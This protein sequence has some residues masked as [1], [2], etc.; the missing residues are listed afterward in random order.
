MRS[1]EVGRPEV[2]ATQVRV[3]EVG[4]GEDCVREHRVRQLRGAQD[5]A[6]EVVEVLVKR[7]CRAVG[8]PL[9]RLGLA[10]GA[11][12][13]GVIHDD[14]VTV[15]RGDDVIRAGDTVILMVT[16]DARSTVERLFRSR[17]N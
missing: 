1:G 15:P 9:R 16:K 4:V 7:D 14:V 11:L 6:A 2:G 3:G 13:V 10:R 8:T 5:G 17:S 12:V